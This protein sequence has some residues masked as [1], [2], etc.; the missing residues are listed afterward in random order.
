[1]PYRKAENAVEKLGCRH[2]F[3]PV[4]ANLRMA[5]NGQDVGQTFP[6]SMP[7]GFPLVF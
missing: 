1:M 3:T 2:P 7:L 4:E 5:R 6:S